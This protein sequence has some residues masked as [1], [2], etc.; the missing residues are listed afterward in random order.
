MSM[1]LARTS[2]GLVTFRLAPALIWFAIA[3]VP[4]AATV[5][6]VLEGFLFLTGRRLITTYVRGF[7]LDHQLV[8]VMLAAVVLVSVTGSVFHFVVDAHAG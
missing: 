7:V 6:C 1:A 2:G 5:L 4:F 8:A 3:L